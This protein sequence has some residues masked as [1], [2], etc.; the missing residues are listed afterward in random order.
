MSSDSEGEY[1]GSEL[2]YFRSDKEIKRVF[3]SFFSRLF[4]TLA[5]AE[6]T[7]VRKYS[8]KFGISLT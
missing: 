5:Y 6:L 3:I 1:F 7:S 2:R 8:N 4:V